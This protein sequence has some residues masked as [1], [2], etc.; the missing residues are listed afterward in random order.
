MS[1][2]STHA[3][4]GLFT[5]GAFFLLILAV[6]LFAGGVFVKE[7]EDYALY[8]NGSVAGLSVGAAVVFRGVPLGKVVDIAIVATSDEPV[9]IRVGIDIV[10]QNIIRLHL[11]E[12]VTNAVRAEIIASMVEQ[13]LRARIAMPSLLTGQARL[14][15]DFFPGSV[16]L[17]QSG[18]KDREIPTV[19]SPLEEFSRVISRVNVDEIAR[20]LLLALQGFNEVIHSEDTKGSL[21][22]LKQALEDSAEFMRGMPKFRALIEH[23]ARHIDDAATRAASEIPKFGKAAERFEQAVAAAGRVLSPDSPSVREL[24]NAM[25]EVSEAAR[26]VRVLAGSLERNP[27]NLLRGK[28]GRRP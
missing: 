14:E 26:A 21:L 7:E 11:G 1:K 16:A 18:D 4:V 17:Y 2:Q 23:V 5:A 13:G 20:N 6:V 10:E 15:L 25:K 8:F 28:G 24:Q 9:T 19:P 12:R 3:K 27:E 22:A